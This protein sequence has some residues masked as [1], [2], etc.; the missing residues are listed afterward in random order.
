MSGETRGDGGT[1]PDEPAGRPLDGAGVGGPDG[2]GTDAPGGEPTERTAATWPALDGA[3][4]GSEPADVP[5]AAPRAAA[6]LAGTERFDA[7]GR[8]LDPRAIA[9]ASLDAD[10][11]WSLWVISLA[12]VL[13]VSLAVAA[14]TPVGALV[15]AAFLACCAV[16]RGVVRGG[17]AALVVRSRATDVTVL[18]GLAVSI[19]VLSQVVPVPAP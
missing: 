2:S 5:G 11:N 18:A 14:G 7:D 12:V 3:P 19:A 15:L 4:P 10:R 13:V 17:P 1:G 6:P 9:R 8:P 16:V